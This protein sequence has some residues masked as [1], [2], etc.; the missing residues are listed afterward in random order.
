MWHEKANG[1]YRLKLT[2]SDTFD[3]HTEKTDRTS[4][5]LGDTELVVGKDT[6]NAVSSVRVGRMDF[7][8]E[9]R[10]SRCKVTTNSTNG[11]WDSHGDFL[12]K[13]N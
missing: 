10:S 4:Q 8:G 11:L 6:V 9:L 1:I 2:V 12:P 13:K 3:T 7:N 5:T